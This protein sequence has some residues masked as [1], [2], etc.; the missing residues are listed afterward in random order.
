MIAIVKIVGIFINKTLFNSLYLSLYFLEFFG[1]YK[2]KPYEMQKHMTVIRWLVFKSVRYSFD[3]LK[4]I[5]FLSSTNSMF[6]PNH[7]L[8]FKCNLQL[9]INMLSLNRWSKYHAINLYKE[10]AQKLDAQGSN[11]YIFYDL[12][13]SVLQYPTQYVVGSNKL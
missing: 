6:E 2:S 12:G 1:G 8:M 10:Q 5:S 4:W 11:K 9:K 7:H 3:N 13:C